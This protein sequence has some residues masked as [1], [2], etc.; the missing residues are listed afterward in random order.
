MSA[1]L[2]KKRLAQVY[3]CEFCEIFKNTFF[4]ERLWTT[5]FKLGHNNVECLLCLSYYFC[6]WKCLG[7]QI[8]KFLR[9]GQKGGENKCS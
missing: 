1:T 5:D 7:K 9:Y 4:T 3:S 6:S 2:L 8:L